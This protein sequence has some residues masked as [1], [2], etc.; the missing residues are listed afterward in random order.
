M[1]S[2]SNVESTRPSTCVT[3]VAGSIRRIIPS[4]RPSV[5][6]RPRLST[7]TV[8]GTSAARRSRPR[9]R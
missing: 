6:S 9:L 4:P 8:I 1:M 5:M 2:R 7:R 3:P